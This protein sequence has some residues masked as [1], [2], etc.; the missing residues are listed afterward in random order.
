MRHPSIFFV[1]FFVALDVDS[2]RVYKGGG[3]YEMAVYDSYSRSC[4]WK[5]LIHVLRTGSAVVD[6]RRHCSLIYAG[7]ISG[8]KR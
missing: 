1:V 4:R 6:E 2:S 7:C 8:L 5:W 3:E